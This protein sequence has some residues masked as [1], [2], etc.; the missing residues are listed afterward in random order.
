MP[1]PYLRRLQTDTKTGLSTAVVAERRTQ[2]G[3]N[4]LPE[5]K[6]N[7]ILVFLGY[8][9]GPMPIMIWYVAC[10]GVAGCRQRAMAPLRHDSPRGT[11]W[12]ALTSFPH[13]PATSLAGWPPE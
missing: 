3:Y 6:V 12:H 9:W 10:C 11:L 1:V 8:F 7:P 5:K 13:P 4:E 2:W